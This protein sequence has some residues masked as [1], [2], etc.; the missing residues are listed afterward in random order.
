MQQSA[1][2]CKTGVGAG[3]PGQATLQHGGG[4][5]DHTGPD[6]IQMLGRL[7]VC[8]VLEHEGVGCLSQH[9]RV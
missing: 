9:Y 4:G 7:E 5:H 8:D 6:V 1:E 2:G 3:V